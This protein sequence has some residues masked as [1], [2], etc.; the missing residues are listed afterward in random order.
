MDRFR[1]A[2]HRKKKELPG[3]SL[4]L[5]KGGPKMKQVP[6]ATGPPDDA[7]APES[8]LRLGLDGYFVPPQRPGVF[9][10]MTKFPG[11][12]ST[13]RGVTMQDLANTLERQ[14]K[15]PVSDATGLT[16]RYDFV[17]DY[18]ME[19]MDVG[20]GR[21][22]VSPGDAETPSDIFSSLQ[23]KLGLKLESNK[24]AVEML[25]IDHVEKSPTEN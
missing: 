2:I 14:L 11:A 8:P 25:V 13:F 22:P 17:L 24:V 15:R 18:T 19:G 21:I 7:A 5:A 12:R 3:Y 1:S 16:A 4:V 10:Q 6:A 9:F 20:R 23:A